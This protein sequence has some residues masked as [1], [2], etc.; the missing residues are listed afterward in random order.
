MWFKNKKRMD[1]LQSFI[2]T[3]KAQLIQFS[4]YMSNGDTKKAQEMFDFYA[5]NLELPDFDPVQPTTMQQLK[6]NASSFFAWIKENQG[7]LMQGY[8]YIR[9]IIANK[10][11]LPPIAPEAPVGEPLPD[12]NA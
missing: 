12:I 9:S 2:P 1:L 6:N 4:M 8:E 11:A 10:G 3:S 7:D 5:K